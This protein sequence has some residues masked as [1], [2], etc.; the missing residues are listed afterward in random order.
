MNRIDTISNFIQ[1]K[2]DEYGNAYMAYEAAGRELYDKLVSGKESSSNI[3]I[4]ALFEGCAKQVG[5]DYID[6]GDTDMVKEAVSKSAFPN[7]TKYVIASVM[8]P[9][10][11]YRKEQL[12]DLYTE[13]E[14]SNSDSEELYGFTGEEGL[15]FVPAQ[16][17][18]SFTDFGEKKCKVVLGK[19]QRAIGLT[20]E[21]IY[22]DKTGQILDKARRIGEKFADQFEEFIIETIEIRPRTLFGFET[23]SDLNCAVFD[24]TKVT[25]SNFYST[26]HSSLSYM[27]GQVNVN[28]ITTALSTSGVTA[29]LQYAASMVDENGD[30]ITVKPSVL[31]VHSAKAATAW[32]MLYSPMQY[33]TTNNAKNPFGP[34]GPYAFKLYHTPYLNDPDDWYL[35]DFKKQLVVLFWEKFNVTKTSANSEMSFMND[36]VVAYKASVGFGAAHRDYRYIIKS[37]P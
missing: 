10:F 14:A 29:A 25:Q 34:Q 23:A 30:K 37:H 12:S 35:G 33:D 13:G 6:Y 22:S 18:V 28:L 5:I 15:E 3:S 11:E 31:L 8:I 9:D 17:P 36:I 32:Q 19:F 4:R 7:I 26:D 16:G 20:K 1:S 2:V 27:G 21:L 24:G